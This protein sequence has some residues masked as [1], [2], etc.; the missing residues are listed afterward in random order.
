ME[1]VALGLIFAIGAAALMTVLPILAAVGG[2][3]AG[4]AV[5][6]VFDDTFAYVQAYVGLSAL[7]PWQIGSTLAF[8]GSFFRST[9]TNTKAS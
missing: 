2:A 1:K 7:A 9:Q 4:W 5:G 8:V 3:I 6:F